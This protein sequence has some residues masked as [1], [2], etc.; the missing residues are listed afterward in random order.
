MAQVLRTARSRLRGGP[1]EERAIRPSDVPGT[2]LN[3]ALLNLSSP[4]DG[5]RAGAF[6]LINEMSRYFKYDMALSTLSV[7][8]KLI[9]QTQTQRPFPD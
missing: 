4:D 8:R 1:S 5:L 7:T 3:V 9:S 2:L 6:Y